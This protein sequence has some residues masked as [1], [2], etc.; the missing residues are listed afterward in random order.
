MAVYPCR[1]RTL[2]ALLVAAALPLLPVLTT[3]V[4]LAAIVKTLFAAMR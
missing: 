1:R 3:T 4:P 2:V